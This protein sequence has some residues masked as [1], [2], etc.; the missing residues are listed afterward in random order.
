[1]ASRQGACQGYVRDALARNAYSPLWNIVSH[2]LR[3]RTFHPNSA[4][5][6]IV[7]ILSKFR[8]IIRGALG[9]YVLLDKLEAIRATLAG[10]A[11][12]GSRMSADEMEMRLANQDS[13]SRATVL[14]AMRLLRA[15][16]TVMP[17]FA[18]HQPTDY[19]MDSPAPR[20]EPAVH[21]PGEVL[22]LPAPP[23]R[24]GYSADDTE[25]L[26]RGSYDADLIRAQI[27][28]YLPLEQP[29]AIMDFGCSTGRVLRH[30]HP[31]HVT[32]GWQLHGVDVQ[33][34]CI[35]WLRQHFP[36]EFIVYTGT[37][38]PT[39]PFADNSLDVIYGLSVFTH[40]KYL[41]DAWLLEL[42][43][44]LR[45]GGL[46]IQSIH[47]EHAWDFYHRNRQERWGRND[48]ARR[49]Y[50]T[51]EMDVDWFHYGDISESQTF[52]KREVARRF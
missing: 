48:L 10:S 41:W 23:D 50:D 36:Q 32:R 31:D 30:F 49:I 44:V 26:A 1:M 43:R 4:A 25:Y 8:D 51:P 39:L 38:L 14:E 20:F 9:T 21:V 42:R 29:I 13:R 7:G 27:R 22:P 40:I 3:L 45:P 11:P 19:Q 17:R 15:E 35:E 2:T 18:F 33:A 12:N 28:R 16:Y 24:H 5:Q 52:W 34:L 37:T 46:L 47:T 6:S